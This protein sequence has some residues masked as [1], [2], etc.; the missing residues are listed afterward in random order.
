M[1]RF[2]LIVVLMIF[3]HTA[4]SGGLSGAANGIA[5]AGVMLQ[6]MQDAQREQEL[7]RQEEQARRPSNSSTASPPPNPGD[8]CFKA[9][10]DAPELQI[11]QSKAPVS[12]RKQSFD[13]LTNEQKPTDIERT[14]IK[15]WGQRGEGC[16]AL[17]AEYRQRMPAKIAA[18][19]QRGYADLLALIAELYSGNLTYGEFAR[20]RAAVNSESKTQYERVMVEINEARAQQRQQNQAIQDQAHA[21]R[22][23][24][25]DEIHA[26][27]AA[28]ARPFVSGCTQQTVTTG[29]VTRFCT[30]CGSNTTCN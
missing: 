5:N 21:A 7:L 12:F 1:I 4:T 10:A 24:E 8:E 18:I 17:D 11:L 16:I 15:T 29:A 2:L 25:L 27:Q 20:R 30:T 9:L 23:R 28:A 14:A 13:M 22:L 26:R 6:S 3:S 19:R